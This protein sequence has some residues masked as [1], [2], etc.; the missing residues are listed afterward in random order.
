MY[1]GSAV[2][3]TA[4]GFDSCLPERL[5]V[6]SVVDLHSPPGSRLFNLSHILCIAERCLVQLRGCNALDQVLH[7]QTLIADPC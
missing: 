2:G 4:T 6:L 3:T 7:H 5:V 1:E